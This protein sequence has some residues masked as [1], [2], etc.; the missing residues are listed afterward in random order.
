MIWTI[1]ISLVFT[2]AYIIF[3]LINLYGWLKPNN[4]QSINNKN[5]SFT[6]ILSARNEESNIGSWIQSINQLDYPTELI[7]III[8]NDHSE[9]NTPNI[10]ESLK[11]K[12]ELKPISL[13]ENEYG[14]K[15]AITKAIEHSNHELIITTDADC[16][17]GKNWLKSINEFYTNTKPS[18]IIAPVKMKYS[19][20][21]TKLQA[22]EFMSLMGSGLSFANISIP[23]LNNGANLIYTKTAF[24]DVNGFEDNSYH[25]SGDDIMLLE[26]FKVKKK[27]ILALF[28]NESTV[29]TTPA[30]NIFDF[31]AQRIRWASKTKLSNSMDAKVV[32][33]LIILFNSSII[34]NLVLSQFYNPLVDFF[35]VQ[36]IIKFVF[37]FLFIFLV[38]AFLQERK[39]IIYYPIVAIMY[40]V[41]IIVIGIGSLK[42]SFEWKGRKFNNGQ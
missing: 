39:L 9:D 37:D 1:T 7:E 17:Y 31:I 5:N 13:A 25:I 14:K 22:L 21:F 34:M 12:F 6:I 27:K 36:C 28:N 4:P 19:T 11:C 24:N 32:G 3:S 29:E 30:K 42:G 38:A 18:M 40:P 15:T 16:S 35:L 23:I 41:Y 10:L 20:L 26:N 2:T 33:V 8:V